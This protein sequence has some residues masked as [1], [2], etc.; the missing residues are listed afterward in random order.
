M[1][2][3]NNRVVRISI[4]I[5]SVALFQNANAAVFQINTMTDS[6]PLLIPHQPV[7]GDD[8][9]GIAISNS[10]VFYSGDSSTGRF[11]ITDLSGGT[12]VG[13]RYDGLTSDLA[14]GQVYSL[15]LDAS[16]PYAG[17]VPQ[18]ITHLL[19]INGATGALTGSSILLSS[20]LSISNYSSGLFAG[21]ERI[22]F[23]DGANAF[24]VDLPSGTVTNLGTV[25]LDSPAGCENTLYWGVAEF[26]GV[27][28]SLVYAAQPYPIVDIVRTYVITGATTTVANFPGGLSDMCSFTVSIP[29]NRWYFH[30]EGSGT[31][32]GQDENIGFAGATFSIQAAPEPEP[33]PTMSVWGLSIF[34]ALLGFIGFS[35]RR[36][37]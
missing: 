16:T 7:T 27:D 19:E 2:F 14:T 34:V 22:V 12:A 32:G 28:V 33:I 36:L 24:N 31:F 3:K 18:S 26:N 13:F 17:S 23:H 6:N 8:R 5:L 10:Q 9:G 20:P 25:A 11:S 30:Y 4:I 29:N 1:W 37:M 15:G 21:H 35:R